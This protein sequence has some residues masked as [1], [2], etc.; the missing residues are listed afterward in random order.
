MQKF[1]TKVIKK[2]ANLR[3]I[4][5]RQLY[6]YWERDHLKKLFQYYEIDCVFDVG[7][8]YGQYAKMLRQEVG[9]QGLI[10]SFEPNPDAANYTKE[11][12]HGDSDWHVEQI[13][14]STSDGKQMF[15]VMADSQFS[16]LSKPSHSETE[17]FRDWNKVTE[18]IEV[19]TETITTAFRRLKAEHGFKKPFLKMDTQGYDVEII[20]HAGPALTEFIGLQSELAVKKLYEN[21]VDY[22]NAIEVYESFGFEMSAFIPNN[23]GHFPHLIETDCIMVRKI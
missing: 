22:R 9:F 17:M 20:S 15:N 18:S 10:L 1:I 21:S 16:S 6:K 12:A 5:Q 3:V 7:A 23:G 13:A 2:I 11:L 14:L 8:N 4:D 19:K